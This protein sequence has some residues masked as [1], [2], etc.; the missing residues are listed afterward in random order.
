MVNDRSLATRL[1]YI[2]F[3]NTWQFSR[4]EDQQKFAEEFLLPIPGASQHD[5][6]AEEKRLRLFRAELDKDLAAE[7][8]WNKE[9]RGGQPKWHRISD[10]Q[11]K[12]VLENFKL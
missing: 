7:E 3:A 2:S 8:W 9:G 12:K 6:V 10:E 4:E 11:R 1:Q 5:P